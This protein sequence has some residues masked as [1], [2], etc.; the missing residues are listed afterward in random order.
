M[1][2]TMRKK[3]NVKRI[4]WATVILIIPAFVVFYGWSSLTGT[5]DSVLPYAAKVDRYEISLEAFQQQYTDTIV[6]LR[7]NYKQDITEDMVKRMQLP[8]KV[9][10]QM[11]GQYL[12]LREAKK[13]GIRVDDSEIMMFIATNQAFAPGGRFDPRL[14]QEW[15]YAR[16]K[17]PAQF[18]S[19]LRLDIIQRKLQF[20]LQDFVKV[21]DAEVKE[22]FRK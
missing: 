17:T 14:Y 19:E 6:E 22:A 20:L 9:L 3:E 2:K 13:L 21:S 5:G 7:N 1:L 10:D 15:V 8:E 11:I 12:V 18:E 16:G 4:M